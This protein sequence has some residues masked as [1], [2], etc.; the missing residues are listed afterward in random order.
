MSDETPLAIKLLAEH[1]KQIQDFRR[2]LGKRYPL[3]YVVV[4][5]VIAVVG[6][7]DSWLDIAAFWQ[8][9]PALHRRLFGHDYG[10]LAHDT[11]RRIFV[12]LPFAS[13]QRCFRDWLAAMQAAGMLRLSEEEVL[14][15]DGKVLR[16]SAERRTGKAAL[17]MVTVYATQTGVVLAQDVV[18]AETASNE[19]AALPNVLAQ[20]E[21]RGHVVVTDAAHAQKPNARAITE[22][23]GEYVFALKRNHAR[24]FEAL[25]QT[26]QREQPE[27]FRQVLHEYLHTEA[28][29]HG[30]CDRREYWLVA[31]AEYLSYFAQQVDAWPNLGAVGFVRRWRRV[32]ESEREQVSFFVT[33]LKQGVRRFAR[34]VRTY[35][36]IEN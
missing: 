9:R 20:V 11:F 34:A 14:A 29:G 5:A 31:D 33:S 6:G 19:I 25:Q 28:H 23:G 27:G 36:R 16:G 4:L 7:A 22:R 12:L 24:L 21:L 8:A 1:A 30:R 2:D 13:I 32:G 35:W 17:Q 26:W 18:R 15:A 3:W 10:T